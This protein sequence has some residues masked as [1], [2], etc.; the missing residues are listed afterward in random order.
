MVSLY[1]T[2]DNFKSFFLEATCRK[3]EINV[4]K[5]ET[6]RAKIEFGPHCGPNLKLRVPNKLAVFASVAG[7]V[8]Q[9]A[10]NLKWRV[11]KRLSV[12]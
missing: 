6:G 4:R 7:F 5:K 12:F 2:Q 1:E 9:C 8:A 3:K 11:Y 10:T